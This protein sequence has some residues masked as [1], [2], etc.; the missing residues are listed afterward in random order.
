MHL[1][2]NFSSDYYG[3]I[4]PKT[5]LKIRTTSQRLIQTDVYIMALYCVMVKGVCRGKGCDFWARVK[6]RKFSL[7]E[8]VTGIRE[9]IVECTSKNAMSIDEAI[10]QYWSQ[11]GVRNM[12]KLCVEEPDLCTKMM[13]AEILARK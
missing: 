6:I 11:I 2:F 3:P 8:L 7:E 4:S 9:S 10:R 5:M 12:D 1:F 13:D